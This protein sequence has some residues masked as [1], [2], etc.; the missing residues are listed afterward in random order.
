MLLQRERQ[1]KLKK[2]MDEVRLSN[3][4]PYSNAIS[5]LNQTT[6]VTNAQIDNLSC[7]SNS[8]AHNADRTNIIEP[9]HTT[10]TTC[11]DSYVS[12]LWIVNS[13]RYVPFFLFHCVFFLEWFCWMHW[14]TWHE[15]VIISCTVGLRIYS[16]T[17]RYCSMS[18]LC[19]SHILL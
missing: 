1:E 8:N 14:I 11:L 13:R 5:Y 2:Q 19:W 4:L 10:D 6:N 15:F 16:S 7:D 3:Q 12:F 18:N 17:R 9:K